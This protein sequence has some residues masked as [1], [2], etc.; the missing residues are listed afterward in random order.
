MN[1]EKIKKSIKTLSV[2]QP[3]IFGK[4]TA[5]HMFE[6]LIITLKISSGKINL[7]KFELTEASQIQKKALLRT[8]MEFPKDILAPGSN[9]ELNPLKL[10]SLEDAQQAFIVSLEQFIQYYADNPTAEP[11]H[12]RFGP[13]TYEEWCTF[14]EK[15]IAHHFSQFDPTC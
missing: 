2:D 3:A 6:H 12:P 13:L 10:A 14:H 7:P 1:T 4:M 9:G 5:Q 11:I 15:H 8:K